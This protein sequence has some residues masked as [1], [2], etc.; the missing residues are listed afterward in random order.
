VHARVAD[1]SRSDE[2]AIAAQG[3]STPPAMAFFVCATRKRGEIS[4]TTTQ[5]DKGEKTDEGKG[6]GR[7]C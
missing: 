7:F 3:V 6:A 4:M 1:D 5:A 2:E